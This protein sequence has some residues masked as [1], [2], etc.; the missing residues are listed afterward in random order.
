MKKVFIGAIGGALAILLYEKIRH[1]A[2]AKGVNDGMNICKNVLDA[3]IK[4]KE[5]GEEP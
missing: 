4:T 2:Y 5:D 1:E 3:C